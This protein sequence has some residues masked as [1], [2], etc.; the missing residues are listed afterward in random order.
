MGDAACHLTH[1]CLSCGRFREEPAGHVCEHCGAGADGTPVE[2]AV[3]ALSGIRSMNTILY[4]RHW[5]AALEFYRQVLGLPE[6]FSN[7][8]FV[9]FEV[10][11][12]TSLSVADAA[13]TSIEP[14]D[15]RGITVSIRVRDLEAVR[16]LL[17]ARGAEPTP[18]TRRF[19]STVFDV[20][21]PEGHRLEFWAG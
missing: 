9:E 16:S 1:V 18:V 17:A 11:P 21:D 2:T 3:R 13:R 12:G 14:S 4:C 8:W 6:T 7:E 19:G 5:P 15:G 20:R 10:V